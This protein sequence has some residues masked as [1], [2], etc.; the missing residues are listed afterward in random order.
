MTEVFEIAEEKHSE[1]W[2]EML[3]K[4]KPPISNTPFSP[5]LP[6]SILRKNRCHLDNTK[7][8]TM[9]GWKPKYPKVTADEVKKT[10]KTFVDDGIWPNA[11]PRKK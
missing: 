6:P 4:S 8:K 5:S 10:L 3:S 7:L 11:T 1:P 9:T 2:L